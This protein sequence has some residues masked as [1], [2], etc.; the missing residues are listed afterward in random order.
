MAQ[1]GVFFCQQDDILTKKYDRQQGTIQ[2][3]FYNPPEGHDRVWRNEFEAK[4]NEKYDFWPRG[5]VAYNTNSK[6]Y[7]IYYD[8]CLKEDVLDK[9]RQSFEIESNEVRFVVDEY[10]SCNACS[11]KWVD[12][13]EMLY[14]SF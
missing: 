13:D 11:H 1:I 4:F 6:Q 7:V 2:G 12:D 14:D 9:V 10:Y 5:R 8:K 3:V